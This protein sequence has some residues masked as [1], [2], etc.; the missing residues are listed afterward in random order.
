MTGGRQEHGELGQWIHPGK[1]VEGEQKKEEAFA[2]SFP[3]V[4]L[5][6]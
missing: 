4:G 2:S 1:V 6:A 5:S 3:L